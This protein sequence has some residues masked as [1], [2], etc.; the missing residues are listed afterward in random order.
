MDGRN[1]RAVRSDTLEI[2]L[3]LVHKF[4]P[5]LGNI[6]SSPTI[7]LAIQTAEMQF[8]EQP[9]KIDPGSDVATISIPVAERLGIVIP[10]RR[11]RIEIKSSTGVRIAEVHTGHIVARLPTLPGL[12]FEWPCLFVPATR[13][14]APEAI[15][16]LTGLAQD[17]T[18]TY[19]TTYRPAT[20]FGILLLELRPDH[21][22]RRVRT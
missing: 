5:V 15:L 20:P 1:R 18:L 13:D 16:G 10:P 4:S 2:Q 8:V 3:P 11:A 6:V 17:F 21:R 7:Y 14:D 22:G 19:D 12:E 9:F